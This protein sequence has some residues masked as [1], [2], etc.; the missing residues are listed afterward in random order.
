VRCEDLCIRRRD[1]KLPAYLPM[2]G[3]VSCPGL[4]HAR[5]LERKAACEKKGSGRRQGKD[6]GDLPVERIGV[7]LPAKSARHKA[8]TTGKI[9]RNRRERG[10]YAIVHNQSSVA[11]SAAETH[12]HQRVEVLSRCQ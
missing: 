12:V 6:R 9:R 4:P 11:Y 2:I 7:R 1:N 5:H 8:E 3:T 10:L